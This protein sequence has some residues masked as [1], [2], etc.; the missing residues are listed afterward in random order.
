M[1]PTSSFFIL[2]LGADKS[3]EDWAI[4]KEKEKALPRMYKI[5]QWARFIGP[6]GRRRTL[7]CLR[8]TQRSSEKELG[9]FSS[10]GKERRAPDV[11]LYHSKSILD[12]GSTGQWVS[13]KIWRSDNLKA[14]W[15]TRVCVRRRGER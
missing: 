15:Y 11:Q 12:K 2:W 4:H 10:R 13:L 5:L 1:T 14:E 9:Q 3:L 6:L 7:T 8:D